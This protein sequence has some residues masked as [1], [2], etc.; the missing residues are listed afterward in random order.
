M[1][2]DTTSRCER[3][4][5]GEVSGVGCGITGSQKG[6][7]VAR[8]IQTWITELTESGLL[9]E[10]AESVISISDAIDAARDWEDLSA[11]RDRIDTAVNV[12]E[13]SEM[14][15]DSL[16]ER[17]KGKKGLPEVAVLPLRRSIKKG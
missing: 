15:A 4:E 16:I 2:I 5:C 3:V 9:V 1:P 14:N 12:G 11:I 8:A 6:V 7:G 13:L 10:E 17:V